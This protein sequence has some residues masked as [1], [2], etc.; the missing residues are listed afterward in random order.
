M[1]RIL[2]LRL[3]SICSNEYSNY[4]KLCTFFVQFEH[5]RLRLG[6]KANKFPSI[7]FLNG[8]KTTKKLYYSI[9]MTVALL[10]KI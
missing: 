10:G 7:Y 5:H 1:Y 2:I 3:K 4:S 9:E 8:K 6:T